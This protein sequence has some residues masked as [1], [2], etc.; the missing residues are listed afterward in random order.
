MERDSKTE[1]EAEA[2][3]NSQLPNSEVV[4][5]SNVVF[6]TQWEPEFTQ[7]QV[8]K[9]WQLLNNKLGMTSRS[10]KRN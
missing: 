7:K 3:V 2:R 10:S 4:A 6:C 9:A 5:K 8:E 1:A